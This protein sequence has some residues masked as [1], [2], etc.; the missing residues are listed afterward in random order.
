MVLILVYLCSILV[1]KIKKK[2]LQNEVSE[3]TDVIELLHID[4]TNNYAMRLIDADKAWHGLTI[5]ALSQSAGKGQR[6][7]QWKDSLGE[8]LLMS[9]VVI[10]K[11][12]IREQFVF[13]AA[14][15]LSV[16]DVLKNLYS[17]WDVAI[18]WPN[19]IVINDKK[20]GGILIENVI[21]GNTWT[22]AVAGIGLN[23]L[24]YSFSKEYPFATS[25][26]I[27]SGFIYDLNTLTEAIHFKILQEIENNSSSI[28]SKYN[29][30]LYK[31]GKQQIFIKNGEE[32]SGVIKQVDEEGK[33]F[34]E[35]SNGSWIKYTHGDVAWKWE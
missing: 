27:A 10:P 19:D 32:Y 14:I 29:S 6:G 25:L 18:K 20:A 24:Q 13:S 26:K 35:L 30:Y 31:K 9:T 12:T 23:V 5:T 8:S 21:R 2:L 4:S 3:S 34:I 1:F 7:R 17:G 22:H 16:A 28:L 33:L 15:A 11:K